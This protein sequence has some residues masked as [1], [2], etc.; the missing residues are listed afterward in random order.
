MY[1]RNSWQRLDGAFTNANAFLMTLANK[2][3]SLITDTEKAR[4][5]IALTQGKASLELR[6]LGG[7][8]LSSVVSYLHRLHDN[9]EAFELEAKSKLETEEVFANTSK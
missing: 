3:S 9:Y 1:I 5:T 2:A 7:I 8:K 6:L 4:A